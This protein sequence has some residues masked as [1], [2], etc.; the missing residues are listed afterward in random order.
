[1]IPTGFMPDLEAMRDGRLRI[2]LCTATGLIT[3]DI[4]ASGKPLAGYPS[5]GS[6]QHPG[7]DL[8]PFGSVI[9][10]G[11]ALP[12]ALSVG[13]P[14]ASAISIIPSG[15]MPYRLPPA[16]GPPLGSRAPPSSLV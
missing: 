7:G 14:V 4:D 6:K 9:S 3:V 5:P 12:A 16:Q 10:H 1:M 15:Q 13:T 8:Y 11:L 2:T